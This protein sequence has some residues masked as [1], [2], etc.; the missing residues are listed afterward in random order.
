MR[1]LPDYTYSSR[2]MSVLVAV[3]A[4]IDNRLENVHEVAAL[5]AVDG[6][7]DNRRLLAT[8]SEASCYHLSRDGV[9]MVVRPTEAP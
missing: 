3:H 2:S 5:V 6:N 1:P 8:E 4:S 9:R 7:G